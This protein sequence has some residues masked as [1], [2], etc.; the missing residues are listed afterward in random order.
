MEERGAI[1]TKEEVVAFMLDL[2]GYR[3]DEDLTRFRILE[4]SFGDGD[5]L[6][7]IVERL[8][9]SYR[10]HYDSDDTALEKL[11]NCVVGVELHRDTHA[12]TRDKIAD[13]LIGHGLPRA[14]ACLLSKRWL[15][16][17][18][19]LLTKLSA[20]FT[21]VVGNPPYLRQEMI[22]LA[23][24][25]AYRK[26]FSTVYDRADLY[27]PFFERGLSLLTEGGKLSFICSDRWMK[28][29]Y[30][31]PL[32][33]LI[34]SRYHVEHYIDMVGT[35]AFKSEV[36]AYPAIFTI[37]RNQD[38]TNQGDTTKV[39]RQPRID[40]PYLERLAGALTTKDVADHPLVTVASH[41]VK[42]YQPWLLDAGEQLS[43]VRSLEERF[44]TLEEAGGKVGIGVAS[45]CD[46]VYI[47]P[48]DEL[49]VEEAR[50]LPLLMASDIRSGTL[51]WAGR[52]I[53]N[54][55]DEHGKVVALADYPK[56]TAFFQE[57]EDVIRK[58]NV[59]KR[60]ATAWY[61]TIDRIYQPLTYRPK[62]LIPDIMD[63]PT[64]V[65]D[66]GRFYPHHNL[67]WITSESWDLRA[68]QT[69][70]RS[71]IT[72]LFVSL[73]SVK[74]RGGYLRYQAQNLRRIRLPTFDAVSV[75]LR[76]R[77][78]ALAEEADTAQV[79]AAVFELYGLSDADIQLI[80]SPYARQARG[81]IFEDEPRDAAL[82]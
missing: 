60:N 77:L 37:A 21:H 41:A 38:D 81:V 55:F 26:T 35:N 31:G 51:S 28:N 82:Q 72:K 23:L 15:V 69:V 58:R 6:V 42:G 64:I 14:T 47:G 45:G 18:D 71:S 7:P 10:K 76:E 44:P 36:T 43:L 48:Y 30:G 33:K 73:Y 3:A 53:V 70:L 16:Q 68:L 52:G 40:A 66:T 2:I 78:R 29:R 56:L 1:Y 46:R 80:A 63:N 34:A 27:I 13:V 8:M 5:F 57:H 9:C 59:A 74:M 11:S 22:P 49:E 61:R 25:D 24:I 75:L 20:S 17:D 50:K 79:D 65:Y 12:Q 67:Y 4:P 62:L 32:R 39:A 19:F 54:P